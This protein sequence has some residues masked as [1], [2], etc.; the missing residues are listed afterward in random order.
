MQCVND[1]DFNDSDNITD[2]YIMYLF[3]KKKLSLILSKNSR[4]IRC[5]LEPLLKLLYAVTRL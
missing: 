4:G 1:D 2:T 3:K 5:L